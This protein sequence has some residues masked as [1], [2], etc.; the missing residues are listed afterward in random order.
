MI[1]Y[2]YKYKKFK[3]ARDYFNVSRNYTGFLYISMTKHISCYY[4]EFKYNKISGTMLRRQGME[5]VFL[6]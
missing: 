4:K 2:N 3:N 1:P 5:L 6:I